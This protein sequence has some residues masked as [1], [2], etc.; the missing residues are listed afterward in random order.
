VPPLA[1]ALSRLVLGESPPVL[2]LLGGVAC[3]GGVVVAR[4]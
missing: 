1:L 2:A 4:R 3:V